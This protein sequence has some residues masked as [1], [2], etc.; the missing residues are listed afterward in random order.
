MSDNSFGKTLC[1]N[2]S[3]GCYTCSISGCNTQNKPNTLSSSSIP[4]SASSASSTSSRSTK[5]DD[6]SIIFISIVAAFF[7]LI[8][9]ILIIF[10][11]VYGDS[12]DIMKICLPD[13]LLPCRYSPV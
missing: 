5:S 13:C 3:E 11:C 1:R 8:V 6:Q 10:V 4:S 2:D 7:L 12:R 9:I